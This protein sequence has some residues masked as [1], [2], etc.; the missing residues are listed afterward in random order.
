MEG[1]AGI[2]AVTSECQELIEEFK[3]GSHQT[4]FKDIT[5]EEFPPEEAEQ[6][7]APLSR[8]GSETGEYQRHHQ[9]Q[10]PRLHREPSQEV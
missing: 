2:E 8:A 3:R 5:M 10:E 7:E 4:G 1:G 9:D 6:E